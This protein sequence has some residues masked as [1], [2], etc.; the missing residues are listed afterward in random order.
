MSE[1]Y[2]LHSHPARPPAP[3]RQ[4][5]PPP[6]G[7]S[8]GTAVLTL[9]L[10]LNLFFI[11]AGGLFLLF[12]IAV[13][14]STGEVSL[15]EKFHSGK[16]TAKDKIAV[17]RIEGLILDEFLGFAHK[18]IEAAGQDKNVKAVVVR[19]DSPGGSIS[20]SD[21]LHRRLVELRDGNA[22]KKIDAKT[23]L[24]VSMGSIAASGGYYIAMP[25]KT[26]VAERT[27][28]TGSIGVY[29]AFPNAAELA[30]RYGVK[31]NIIKEGEVKASGSLFKRMT[32]EERQLWQGSVDAAFSQFLQV[33]EDGR[34]NLK[35]KLREIVV[36]KVMKGKGE[37]SDKEEVSFHYVRRR[38][39]GG[40]YTAEEALKLGLIDKIGYLD[41]AIK[42]A[43]QAAGLGDDYKSIIYDRPF[44]LQEVLAGA[45]TSQSH[46]SV[47][48]PKRLASGLTPRIWYLAPGAE[49]A[50]M[51]SAAK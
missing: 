40:I 39:D 38:A 31:M 50:G 2:D 19:I 13:A 35:G 29:A 9:S 17:I 46:A 37:D 6:R 8:V 42:E 1:P 10:F 26:L 5:P 7:P 23:H 21:D 28:V 20:A 36:D 16:T 33:V 51:L 25:A 27:A 43:K 18:Q 11:V 49:L 45:Q 15:Q 3:P 22:E 30:D 41:D 12:V 34:P 48:D 47:L 32:P 44:S 4:A 24:V 14:A